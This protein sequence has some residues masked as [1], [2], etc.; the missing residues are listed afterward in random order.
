MAEDAGR[1]ETAAQQQHV[2][3]GGHWSGQNKIPTGTSPLARTCVISCE[4]FAD[5]L[6]LKSVNSSNDWTRTRRAEMRK[7][8]S[9]KSSRT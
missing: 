8:T 6:Y 3:P 7:L 5:G 4:T 1:K 9:G 2:G